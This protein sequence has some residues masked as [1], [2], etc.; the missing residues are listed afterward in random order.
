MMSHWR[1]TRNFG[2]RSAPTAAKSDPKATP[3]CMKL[4]CRA[5][6][7]RRKNTPDELSEFMRNPQTPQNVKG[8]PGNEIVAMFTSIDTE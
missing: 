7:H 2:P 3:S 5:H 8:I 4:S 6:S 1:R